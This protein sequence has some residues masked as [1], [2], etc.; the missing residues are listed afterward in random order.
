MPSAVPLPLVPAVVDG[1]HDVADEA[2]DELLQL[3]MA[4]Q[5]TAVARLPLRVLVPDDQLALF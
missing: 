2:P 4:S 1:V 3:L 5:P